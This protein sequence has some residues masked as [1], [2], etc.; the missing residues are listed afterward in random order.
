MKIINISDGPSFKLFYI[1]FLILGLSIYFFFHIWILTLILFPIGL[2]IFLSIKGILIDVENNRV[3]EY[4]NFLFLKIGTWESLDQFQKIILT[5][6]NQS[7]VLTTRAT[8]STVNTKTFDIYL[9]NESFSNE[10]HLKEF[11][12]YNE[13]K[14]FLD[15]YASFLNLEFYDE[16]AEIRDAISAR[17]RR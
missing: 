1:G 11:T 3:K 8:I 6:T 12:D 13:A 15:K 14:D 4:F 7:Q 10:K 16:V 5:R 2:S 17:G 9:C